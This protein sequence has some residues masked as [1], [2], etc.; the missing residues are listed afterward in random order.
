MKTNVLACLLLLASASAA[1]AQRIPPPGLIPFP[2]P[3][4]ELS[5]TNSE[6]MQVREM[7]VA[8]AVRGLHATV[9]TTL[10]FHNPNPRL[11]EGDLIFPLPDGAAVCGYALDIHGVLVDGVVVRKEKARVA[12]ETET[13]RRVDPGLV[14]HIKGNLYRT[15]I[16]PL[17]AHGT[18]TIRLTYTTP[19]ALAPDGDAALLLPMPRATL[20]K[21]AVNIEVAADG[22]PAPVLGGLGDRRFERAENLWRVE[23]VATNASLHEDIWVALPQLPPQLT[24]VEQAPDGTIW[25]SVSTLAPAAAEKSS[26]PPPRLHVLWDA[27][28]SR[29]AANLDKEHALLAALPAEAF[30]LTVFRDVPEPLR[31]FSAAAELVSAVKAAPLDGGSGFAALAAAIPDDGAPV[32]MFTDGLDTLSG[33]P[34]EFPGP[35]PLAIV[36][37]TFA[38]RESLRQACAGAL[39]DLQTTGLDAALREIASPAPRIAGLQGTGIAHIQGLGR[40]AAGRGRLLGQLTAP[41]ATVQIEY[42]GGA[43]S[44]PFILRAADARA[45]TTLATAWAA[46]RVNQLAPRAEA[47]EDELL[48]LGRKHGLVSPATSLIVLESLDQW[49]RHEIEPP[50]SLPD[51]REQY[52]AAF[53]N[54][55]Q[56]TTDARERH[57]EQLAALW[58]QRVEWWKTDFSKV[59]PRTPGKLESD[60]VAFMAMDMGSPAARAAA[61]AP[62]VAAPDAELDET[63][64]DRV[65]VNFDETGNPL[66]AA[67]GAEEAP[68]APARRPAASI[69]IKEWSPDTPYLTAIRAATG[70]ERYAAYLVQRRDW[71]QSPAFFLDCAGEFLKT[72]PALGLRILSN[73]AELRIEDPALLRVYAWR[74]RQA[75]ELDRAAVLLRR[76]AKLRPEEPQSFRDLALVLAERG[77]KTPDPADLA[78]AMDLLLKV[79]LTPWGRHADSIPLFALEELNALVAWID[80]QEW[81]ARAKPAIPVYDKNLRQNLDTDIRIVLSWDADATDIDLHVVEPGGEEASFRNNRTLRGGLVSRD[82]TDGYGPEEYLIRRAPSGPYLIKANYYG[83]RQQTLVG[84]ATVTA[85]VFTD[86]GR[87]GEQRQVL[88]LRL[89]KPREMVEVG[90]I[91]FG[92]AGAGATASAGDFAALRPGMSRTEVSAAVGTP[93]RRT[94]RSWHYD[95][96]SRTWTVHFS[97]RGK[98]VRVVESLPGGIENIVVQ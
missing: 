92:P 24:D 16:Y 61:P 88:T 48:A 22:A 93:N 11:L 4:I 7:S 40:P 94:K 26:P 17:P 46:A 5:D 23:S 64:G 89:D 60:T 28:G 70:S 75:G 42:A 82:I 90:T 67:E 55:G 69:Q 12:F 6:P 79:V 15:R 81:P 97:S 20:G 8:A 71:A 32:L 87:A 56:E 13:R 77:R 47:F 35:K 31:E 80:R 63:F 27:S 10:V 33:Q 85:T 52:F 76:L 72:D 21:L 18:R 34:L 59:Q 51:M 57:L 95:R 66:Y 43:R 98:L 62:R 9:A 78:E 2:P 36:S 84:P 74:L 39:I 73:L 38:D 14:E 25:F 3:Q 96:E 30:T 58:K 91:A 83:S 50:A 68:P 86:W 49:V 45:G 29:A 65:I 53:K 19:L 37:Q 41:E 1:A 54:R 44:A